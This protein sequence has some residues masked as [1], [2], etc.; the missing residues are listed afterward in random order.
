MNW[1]SDHQWEAWL[2]LCLAFA[3]AEMLSLD[4]VFIMLAGGAGVGA[5]SASLGAPVL[6]SALLAFGTAIALLSLIRPEL[7]R[8]L[9]AGV[10]LRTGVDALVGRRALVIREIRG[11]AVGRVK[12]GG[13]EWAALPYDED[14][15]F[16]AGEVVDVVQIT[17]ATAYVLRTNSLGAV[18]DVDPI[19][20][21][22]LGE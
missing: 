1:L 7:M 3:A 19:K 5:L 17:G 15:R 4:L 20:P 10:N 2:V 18:A 12:I 22:E 8:R 11:Q 16:A 13:E 9:H 6:V 14:D 21:D